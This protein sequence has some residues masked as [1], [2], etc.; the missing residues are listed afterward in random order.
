MQQ[1]L[2]VA[3]IYGVVI[4][5]WMHIIVHA[6]LGVLLGKSHIALATTPVLSIL[7]L[8]GVTVVLIWRDPQILERNRAEPQ[9]E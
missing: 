9:D 3:A 1:D 7:T 4:G 8:V 2:A 5:A 6:S